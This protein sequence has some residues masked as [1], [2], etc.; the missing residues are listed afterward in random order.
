MATVITPDP[1]KPHV[2]IS[3]VKV[4][5]DHGHDVCPPKT[6]ASCVHVIPYPFQLFKVIFKLLTFRLHTG[7]MRLPWDYGAGKHQNYVLL[8]EP[9]QNR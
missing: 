3:A 8:F 7:N 4:P 9:W 6:Q 1:G 2:E 5:I